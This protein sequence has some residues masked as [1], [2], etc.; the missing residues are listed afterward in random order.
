MQR[1]TWN[2]QIL[3]ARSAE[4][5]ADCVLLL[6]PDM[7]QWERAF[8]DISELRQ[9]IMDEAEVASTEGG[10]ISVG[11]MKTGPHI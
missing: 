6:D 2:V 3:E 11:Q 4:V 5:H 8:R 10:G 9:E 1:C 7:L